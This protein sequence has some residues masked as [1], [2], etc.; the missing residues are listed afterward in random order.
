MSPAVLV[1]LAWRSLWRHRRRTFI[2]VASIALGLTLVLFAKQLNEGAYRQMV[3][4]AVRMQAGHVTVEHADYRDAPAIDLT[5]RIADDLRA[6]IESLE[7]V[8]R[9]KLLVSGQGVARTGR[10]AVGVALMGIEPGVVRDASPFAKHIVD[11]E[12]LAPDDGRDVVLGRALAERLHLAVGKKLVLSSNDAHGNLVEELFRVRGIF[13]LGADEIDGYFVE[14]PID[15]LRGLYGLADDEA[16]QL[17]VLLHD[18][19]D[20]SAVRDTVA[21]MLPDGRAVV[22]PWREVLPDLAGAIQLDR[23]SDGVVLGLLLALTLFTIFNTLFM[24]V[25]ERQREMTVQ[26]AL[27]TPPSALRLQV[28]LESVLVGA[29]GC[30][31]G[32]VLGGLWS[33]RV[34]QVG[35]DLSGV[36]EDGATMSGFAM[37]PVIHAHVSAA[38]MAEIVG[39]LY[40]AI[41]LLGLVP[42]RRI[43]KLDLAST[44]R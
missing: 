43:G 40:V 24:S 19:D 2:T 9:T 37:D 23:V 34:Q 25:L 35:L 17:G 41:L 28:F 31:F 42:M 10:G 22:L 29:L 44:L 4:D 15:A 13:E 38:T 14:A 11:G 32:T 1:R 18:P 27:G 20:V 21:G 39:P 36:M 8:E 6:R 33:Y 7:E 30:G 26:L 3:D 16:T 5:V 12:Y